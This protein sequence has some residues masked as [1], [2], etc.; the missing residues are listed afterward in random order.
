MGTLFLEV[1][2]PEKVVISQEVDMVVAPGTEGEF[3]I[4]PEHIN[5]LSGIVPGELRF[6]YGDK[7]EYMAVASGFAEVSDNK[8]SIL[9]DSAEKAQDI[10]AERAQK[11]MDRAKKRLYK[12]RD[13]ED[14]DFLRAEMALKKSIA[15]IKV[16]KKSV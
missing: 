4:L 13:K 7:Q 14:T 8:V 1:V 15:R 5:F 12:D 6:T 11:A 10:N 3:G 16:R 9:V 2:T